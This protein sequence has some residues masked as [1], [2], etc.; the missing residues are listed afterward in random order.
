MQ[1]D[2]PVPAGPR[3]D[4]SWAGQG[5]GLCGGLYGGL[6]CGAV[7]GGAVPPEARGHCGDPPCRGRT[8]R[9]LHRRP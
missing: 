3:T 9:A 5:R 7:Q 2:A 4:P 8:D 6:C 1:T